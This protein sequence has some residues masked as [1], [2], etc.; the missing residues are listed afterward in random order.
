MAF[1]WK[2]L[3]G[4]KMSTLSTFP[5]VQNARECQGLGLIDIIGKVLKETK[6]SH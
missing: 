3:I 2:V 4:D 6:S 1:E 5:V